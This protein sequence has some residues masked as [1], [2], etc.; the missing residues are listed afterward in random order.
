MIRAI[1]QSN[2]WLIPTF[3]LLGLVLGAALFL[4][5]RHR[6]LPR[7][8]AVLFGLALAAEATATLYP[9]HPGADASGVCTLNRD[10]FTPLTGQQGVMNIVMFIP[11]AFFAATTFRRYAL[12]LA[13]SIL[14][15]G[16][17]ELLQAVTPH[18]GR[19]C[20]SEDLVANTL[21]A[22]AGAGL[23]ALLGSRRGPKTAAKAEPVLT[24]ADLTRSAIVLAL[25]GTVLALIGSQAVTPVFAEVSELTQASTAQHRAAEKAVHDIFGDTR[26]I[27]SVQY[28][29]APDAD[30]GE[31]IVTLDEGFL[32]ILWPSQ[33]HIS[34]ATDT[35]A[36]PG[37]PHHTVDSDEDAVRQATAF[38][39]TRFPWA[40][41]DS[42]TMVY[43]TVAGAPARTVSWR[44]RIDGV[45]MPMRMDVV[46][47][48]TGR[49]SAFTARDQKPPANLPTHKLTEEQARRAAAKYVEMD[50]V[51]STEILVEKNPQGQ[52]ETRWAIGYTPPKPTDDETQDSPTRGTVL[53][54]ATTGEFIANLT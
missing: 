5:A 4:L 27:S 7:A 24:K 9:M 16:A 32:Q 34:G 29:E 22:I 50:T 43:P 42:E 47:E 41:K 36:F 40:L 28:M 37:V 20:A 13:G 19:S 53:I 49:I 12:P 2:P 8:H 38:V 6:S 44:Q 10:L 18:V 14:L 3:L 30:A 39:R 46:V 48:P 1:T 25:G 52:W 15:S 54:N 33:D 11:V 23:A 35:T 21:G 17:T 31:L 26:T 51:T 45:L